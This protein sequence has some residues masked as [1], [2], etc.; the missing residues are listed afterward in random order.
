MQQP[1]V[2]I[3]DATGGMLQTLLQRPSTHRWIN[4][5]GSHSNNSKLNFHL[6]GLKE[7]WEQ[8]TGAVTGITIKYHNDIEHGSETHQIPYRSPLVVY[9]AAEWLSYRILHLI[10]QLHQ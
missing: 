7:Y 8:Q 3:D 5:H 10:D 9:Y 4:F 1:I 6:S 2:I